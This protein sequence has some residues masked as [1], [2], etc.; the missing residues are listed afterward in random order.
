MVFAKAK[1]IGSTYTEWVEAILNPKP[2]LLVIDMQNDFISGSLAVTGANDIVD[3]IKTLI[4]SSIWN[5]V[6]FS[7]IGIHQITYHFDPTGIYDPLILNGEKL[8][9][10]YQ[11][12][13]LK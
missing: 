4:T 12:P 9:Q 3:G 1:Q 7:R 2:A 5:E 11:K 13:L 6:V 10:E 8:T